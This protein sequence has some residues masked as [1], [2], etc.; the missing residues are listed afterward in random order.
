MGERR[1]EDFLTELG[2]WYDRSNAVG[3]V[4]GDFRRVL[5]TIVKSNSRGEHQ[6]RINK[7]DAGGGRSPLHASPVASSNIEKSHKML[8]NHAIPS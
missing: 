6:L 2:I 5:K 1:G 4:A 7:V 3:T 8:I